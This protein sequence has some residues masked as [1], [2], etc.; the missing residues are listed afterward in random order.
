MKIR[1]TV[2][3]YVKMLLRAEDQKAKITPFRI[4]PHDPGAT[5]IKL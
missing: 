4:L 3:E 1:M 2:D 5:K